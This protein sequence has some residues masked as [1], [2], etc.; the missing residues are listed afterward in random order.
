MDP[1]PAAK[2]LDGAKST[3][4]L[5]LLLLITGAGIIVLEVEHNKNIEALIYYESSGLC[6][7][8]EDIVGLNSECVNQ[9]VNFWLSL[10]GNVT[11]CEFENQVHVNLVKKIG[12]STVIFQLSVYEFDRLVAQATNITRAIEYMWLRQNIAKARG[13]RLKKQVI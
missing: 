8:Q 9:S 2:L 12:N 1:K 6:G 4:I 13:K 10:K 11:I 7:V 3:L 5:A